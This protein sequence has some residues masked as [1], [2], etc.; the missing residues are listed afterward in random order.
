MTHTLERGGAHSR[1]VCALERGGA[2]SSGS[3]SGPPWWAVGAAVV[4]AMPHVF[5][6]DVFGLDFLRV[7]SGVSPVV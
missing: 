5:K 2:C 1:E 3:L 6:R 4:W 7:L